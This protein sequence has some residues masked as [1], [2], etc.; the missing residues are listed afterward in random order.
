MINIFLN[1]FNFFDRHRA[2]LYTTI[3]ALTLVLT[4]IATQTKIDENISAFFP[5]QDEQTDF[6]LNN[7][8]GLDKIIVAIADTES[9]T[10]IYDLID[11]AED[12]ADTLNSELGNAISISL[13]YDDSIADN[14]FAELFDNLPIYLTDN[15]LAHIDTL[16]SEVNIHDSM[17]TN[18]DLMLSP[19]SSGMTRLL[20]IDPLG[21]SWPV[22]DR[23]KDLATSS[24]M[25]I[26]DG[27]MF[28]KSMHNLL[29]FIDLNKNFSN[30]GDNAEI[31]SNIRNITNNLSEKS[32]FDIYVYGAPVVAVSNS[33]RVKMDEY[34]TLSIAIFLMIVVILLAFRQKK[35]IFLVLTPVIFG[36]LFAFS[37]ISLAGIHISLMAIGAG[38]TILGVALSYSIHMLTHSVH[39]SSKTDLL[40]DMVYPMTVGSITTIGAFVGLIFTGE[41]ILHDLGLFASLALVG[42]LIFCLIFLP[43]FLNPEAE[44]EPTRAMKFVTKIA[45]FDYSQSKIILAIITILTLVCL[46]FFTDVQFDADM[47]KLNYQDDFLTKSQEKIESLLGANDF[48]PVVVV[49]DNIDDLA[50]QAKNLTDKI[51]DFYVD[52]VKSTS[53]IA[54]NFLILTAVQQ[55][56]IQAWNNFWTPDKVDHLFHTLD[57][58][59][60]Q[61]GFSDVAFEPFKQIITK[62][63]NVKLL[64]ETDIATSPLYSNWIWQSNGKFM[65]YINIMIVAVN[66]DH[67]LDEVA[68]LPNTVV[69]DM[70][71]FVRKATGNIVD[72]FNNILII[73]SLLVAIVLLISYG[74]FELFFMTF[75]PMCISW[76]LILGMMAIFGVPFNIIN[77]ILS[78]F[79]FGVGDDFAIFIMDGL[80]SEYA[81]GKKILTSHKTAIALSALAII[82]GLGVHVFALHPAVKSIGLLSIF[83]LIAVIFT[84]YIVQPILF[85]IFI[86]NPAQRGFPASLETFF[87]TS[88]MYGTFAFGCL[89]CNFLILCLFPIPISRKKKQKVVRIFMRSYLIQFLKLVNFWDP[90]KIE[91]QLDLSQPRIIIANHQSFLDLILLTTFDLRIIFVTKSWVN[92]NPI[93]GLMTTYSGFYDVDEGTEQ[94]TETLR[95]YT[96][97]GFS[98]M[99]FPEGTRSQNSQI[100]RFH[101]GAF[102]LAEDLNLAIAPVLFYG[103]NLAIAKA[104]TMQI[105]PSILVAKHLPLIQPDDHTFGDNYKTRA[106]NIAIYMRSEL[107]KLRLRVD[108]TDNPYYRNALINNYLYKGS[109]IISALRRRLKRED[110]FKLFDQLIPSNA[111]IIDFNCAYGELPFLLALRSNDRHILA[112]DSDPEK[113]AL[114]N[115][116]LLARRLEN[117]KFQLYQ[118]NDI[119]NVDVIIFEKNVNDEL[120]GRCANSLNINGLM[121]L[122]SDNPNASMLRNFTAEQHE[123]WLILRR[124]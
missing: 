49:S 26:V 58:E 35:S 45:S 96:A 65:L 92:R 4:L 113:I 59:A 20:P 117:L 64:S 46:F 24:S 77:I 28:D 56:R 61:Y 112:Y 95:K 19:L 116:S 16:I 93:F 76:V 8:K 1:I 37:V 110:N 39:S 48:S 13:Y 9:A 15:D 3:V 11:V 111:S 87:R 50:L 5:S 6:V 75:L 105:K 91:G 106:K 68:S 79:I 55:Q 22:L 108:S 47:T 102:K 101:R 54:P 124:Q 89:I 52:E 10:Q 121:I 114:A 115:H 63:Y 86:S 42:T 21:F 123:N 109:Q 120:L 51:N 23:L 70:G 98:I 103:N 33:Q 7:L 43:H 78:T 80:Q 44:K 38:S 104:Q 40:R 85:R 32:N 34:I 66:Q 57:R 29:I 31:V 53:S 36:V 62:T 81:T 12:L 72:D 88:A 100:Q 97:E 14:L 84:S 25:T 119:D 73:S 17:A 69:T 107:Q 30:T 122:P 27:Y 67:I 60:Q 94:M 2:V 41:K 99:I 74:R 82:V 83:G 90:V 118:S 71:Y 18:R